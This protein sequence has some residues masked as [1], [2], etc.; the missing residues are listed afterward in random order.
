MDYT[1]IIIGGGPAGVAAGVYASRKRLKTALITPDFGGQ[2]LVS[3]EIQNFI[4]IPSL[5]GLEMAER[6]RK[7]LEA[8][9]KDVLEIKEGA[10]VIALEKSGAKFKV[11]TEQG[12]QYLCRAVLV[13]A[14]SSRRRLKVPGASQLDQ[15]GISYCA[16]CDAP[17]LEGKPV[18]VI[19]GGN[20]GFEAAQQLLSYSPSITLLEYAGEF[21]ADPAV[22]QNVSQNPRFRAITNAEILEVYGKDFV[23]GLR[24]KDRESNKTHELKVAGIFVEIGSVPNSDFMR[25]LLEKAP[26]PNWWYEPPRHWEGGLNSKGEILVDHRTQRA[27]LPGIWAAGDITDVLYRQINISMG[28]AVKAL[29]DIYLYLQKHG[30]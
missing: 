5:S 24:Y 13:C 12:N 27:A 8:Y 4:G 10:K 3:P 16:S 6:F 9:G 18:V 11:K 7:H 25:E 30:R 22:V 23:E 28:D 2:S 1:L 15:R 19:G 29:E 26:S 17:L 14:G 20:A 21:R